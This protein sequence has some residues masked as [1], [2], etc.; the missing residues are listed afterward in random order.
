MDDNQIKYQ[1]LYHYTEEELQYKLYRIVIDYDDYIKRI[2]IRACCKEEVKD[3]TKYK[4]I[5]IKEI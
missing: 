1:R 4:V 3:S 2:V 5:S